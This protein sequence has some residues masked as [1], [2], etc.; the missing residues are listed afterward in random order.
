MQF[1]P[2]KTA[3]LDIHVH[4]CAWLNNKRGF[5]FLKKYRYTAKMRAGLRLIPMHITLSL[6]FSRSNPLSFLILKNRWKIR[7]F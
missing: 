1:L 7:R 4:M 5:Y 3:A 2:G 6:S